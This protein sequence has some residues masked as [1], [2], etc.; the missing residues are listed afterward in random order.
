MGG[1]REE[2]ERSS[3]IIRRICASVRRRCALVGPYI[4]GSFH[5]IYASGLGDLWGRVSVFGRGDPACSIFGRGFASMVSSRA[6]S[7]VLISRLTL[8]S[9][10]VISAARVFLIFRL[11]YSHAFL[12]PYT[13]NSNRRGHVCKV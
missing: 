12:L 5:C 3:E 6:G 10:K 4:S 8:G 2:I 1:V 9:K 11:V 13:R 7:S